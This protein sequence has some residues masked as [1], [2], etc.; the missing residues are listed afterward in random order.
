VERSW[1]SLR[2]TLELGTIKGFCGVGK[3]EC[4]TEITIC[5]ILGSHGDEYYDI[6]KELTAYSIMVMS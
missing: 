1:I 3:E 4:C 6:S 5:E 2:D